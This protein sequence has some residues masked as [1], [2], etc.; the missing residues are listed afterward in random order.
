MAD[1][2]Y[3]RGRITDGKSRMGPRFQAC[4]TTAEDG[5]STPIFVTQTEV[6]RDHVCRPV[7][8]DPDGTT[9]P[10]VVI[11][12]QQHMNDGNIS[13]IE[14]VVERMYPSAAAYANGYAVKAEADYGWGKHAGNCDD[15]PS[16]INEFITN[17]QTAANGSDRTGLFQR[18]TPNS[19]H[20]YGPGGT[21]E[22]ATSVWS[23][24]SSGTYDMGT[25]GW[26]KPSGRIQETNTYARSRPTGGTPTTDTNPW[27]RPRGGTNGIGTDGWSRPSSA[28]YETNTNGWGTP[29]G[30]TNNI[31]TGGWGRP[32]SK[33]NDITTNGWSRPTETA[34]YDGSYGKNESSLDEYHTPTVT[35]TDAWGRPKRVGWAKPSGYESNITKPTSDIGAAVDYI[36]ESVRPSSATTMTTQQG[37]FYALSPTYPMTETVVETIDSKEAA[38]RYGGSSVKSPTTKNPTAATIDSKEAARKYNGSFV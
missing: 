26:S 15:Q 7:I 3:N 6:R 23:K 11:L 1:Y 33:N 12:P 24:P 20:S 22:I 30:G 13:K 19:L 32:S 29:I 34:F 4:D 38:K 25:T 10:G 37:R 36:N 18:R 28:T 35:S 8:V 21:D 31:G 17:V 5:W 9:R 27:G 16:K 14:T 2:G